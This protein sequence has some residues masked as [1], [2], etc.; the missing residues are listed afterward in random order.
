MLSLMI[1]LVSNWQADILS[2]DV[3]FWYYELRRK[4]ITKWYNII[5]VE[6]IITNIE[7]RKIEVEVEI[8]KRGS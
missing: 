4:K 5:N 3:L 7:N 2:H 1:F 6:N 8:E